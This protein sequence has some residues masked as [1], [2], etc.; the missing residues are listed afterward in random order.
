M[1]WQTSPPQCDCRPIAKSEGEKLALARLHYV[2]AWEDDVDSPRQALVWIEDAREGEELEI[3]AELY[4]TET[5]RRDG[6]L[7]LVTAGAIDEATYITDEENA[8]E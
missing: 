4:E 2:V 5:L 6:R 3:G 7:L 1:G 8:D